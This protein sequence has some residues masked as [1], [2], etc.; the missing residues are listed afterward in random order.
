MGLVD[1]KECIPLVGISPTED[2]IH[3]TRY[4]GIH[5]GIIPGK[6]IAW[7]LFVLLD[8][9]AI[10]NPRVFIHY[11]AIPLTYLNAALLMRTMTWR[12]NLLGVL[13]SSS[14]IHSLRRTIP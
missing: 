14:R 10:H 7:S 6:E 12:E 4:K 9:D 13:E 11:S 8:G 5:M 3:N 2:L 1:D